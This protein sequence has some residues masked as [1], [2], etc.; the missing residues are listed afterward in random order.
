MNFARRT[1]NRFGVSHLDQSYNSKYSYDQTYYPK[2]A[3]VFELL[4]QVFKIS[5]E[6][7]KAKEEELPGIVKRESFKT[8]ES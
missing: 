1:Q 8:K 2:K 3:Q 6:C 7:K 5:K 4:F